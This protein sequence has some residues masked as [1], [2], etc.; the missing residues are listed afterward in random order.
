MSRPQFSAAQRRRLLVHRHLLD[1]SGTSPRQVTNALV[2]VHATDPAT[3]YLSILARTTGVRIEDIAAA[4][5]DQRLLVRWLAMR[6]TVFLLDRDIVPD[7]QAAVSTPLSDVLRRRLET[8]LEKNKALPDV[9]DIP[10]WVRSVEANVR[11]AAGE[12]G[13]ATGAQLSAVEPRMKTAI[14]PRLPSDTKQTVTSSLLAMMSAAGEIVRGTPVGAWTTR[15]HRWQSVSTWWE[16]GVPPRDA[17]ESRMRLAERWLESYGPATVDDLQW[18][19]GWTKTATRATLAALHVVDVDLDGVDGIDLPHAHTG[20]A[21]VAS[22]PSAA[23]LPSLDSTAMGWK[24]RH[25]YSPAETAGL[26]DNRGNIGPT[27]WW[28]GQIVGVWA[29]TVGGIRIRLLEDIGLEAEDAISVAAADL[30]QKLGGTVVTPSIRV[31]L[32]QCLS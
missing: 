18:W 1:Q 31:P 16:D 22:A 3:P 25:W 29:S 6:R 13:D 11:A 24:H 8:V 27:I 14:P 2:A 28:D 23:L 19:T 7:V 20:H 30:E 32:E 21:N 17:V 5:Y 4:M 15:Q 12:I 10:A 26:Y 9:P